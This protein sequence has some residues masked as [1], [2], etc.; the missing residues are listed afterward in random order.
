MKWVARDCCGPWLV[1]FLPPGSDRDSCWYPA[2]YSMVRRKWGGWEGGGWAEGWRQQPLGV[3]AAVYTIVYSSVIPKVLQ[4]SS[5]VSASLVTL[6]PV[7]WIHS[8]INFFRSDSR[9]HWTPKFF[10]S[11]HMLERVPAFKALYFKKN[12]RVVIIQI[13]GN[14]SMYIAKAKTGWRAEHLVF[15]VFSI[16][17]NTETAS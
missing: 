4:P 15:P 12:K 14:K 2:L 16:L 11:V 7:P 3:C 9:G 13:L 8:L 10:L 17:L 5:A 1:P 6:S